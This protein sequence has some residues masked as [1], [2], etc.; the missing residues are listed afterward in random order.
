M[1][2]REDD[3]LAITPLTVKDECAVLRFS[4]ELDQGSEQFYL[5]RIGA[6][7]ATGYRHLVLDVT[8]LVFCDSR[9][10]NC[11]LALRWLLHRREGSLLLACVGRRLAAVLSLTGST[12]VLPV[13]SS[14]SQ[15][16]RTLPADQRPDWP[17]TGDTAPGI[18]LH[19][20]EPLE[21]AWQ[22]EDNPHLPL[23]PRAQ[24]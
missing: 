9:G 17:P 6:V 10:L 21:A 19:N 11:L 22:R 3:R 2:S 1:R 14:V 7:V 13:Y 5:D 20:P 12:E 23:D 24:D 4:G 16:L 15:A 8:A 18:P